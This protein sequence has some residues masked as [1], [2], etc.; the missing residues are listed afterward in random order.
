MRPNLLLEAQGPQE[1]VQLR[2]V[3]QTVG[4][5]PLVQILDA[6]VAQ[7]GEQLVSFFKFL[8]TQ[9]PVEQVIAVPK[10]LIQPRLVDCDQRYPQMAEQLVEVPTIVSYSLL[11]RT[12][13][14]H[15]DNPVPGGGGR[16][17]GLQ[18]FY[19]RTEFHSNVLFCRTHF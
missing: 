3:E 8:D 17:A 19:S 16:N 11:Q 12:V 18:G 7:T 10:I 15:V 6:L 2:S 4:F 1:R 14:Q 9:M 13:E 5:A